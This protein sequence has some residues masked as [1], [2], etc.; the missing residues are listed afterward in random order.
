M[1]TGWIRIGLKVCM[2][3]LLSVVADWEEAPGAIPSGR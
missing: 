2:V 1:R 3:D